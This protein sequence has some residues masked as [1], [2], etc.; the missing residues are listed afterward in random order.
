MLRGQMGRPIDEVAVD[1]PLRVQ[2]NNLHEWSVWV[3]TAGMIAAFIAFFL[4]SNRKFGA[5]KSVST[6]PYN[7]EKEFKI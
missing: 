5:A 2:F 6:D 3:L 4:I 1:D 7:F